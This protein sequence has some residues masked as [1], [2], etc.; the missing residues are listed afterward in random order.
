MDNKEKIKFIK[1]LAELNGKI[2]VLKLENKDYSEV[3]QNCK[4]AAK[5]LSLNGV[6]SFD[7][8]SDE[9][10]EASMTDFLSDF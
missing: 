3:L 8:S 5:L 6:G 4:K 1:G 7:F 10:F 2:M 9:A